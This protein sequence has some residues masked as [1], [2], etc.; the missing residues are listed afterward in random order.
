M[1]TKSPTSE[2]GIGF[3][4]RRWIH[5]R[6][7]ICGLWI[8]L[9]AKKVR[10]WFALQPIP[11]KLCMTRFCIRNIEWGVVVCRVD[12]KLNGFNN[13]IMA[14]KQIHIRSADRNKELRV[15]QQIF[16]WDCKKVESRFCGSGCDPSRVITI[17]LKISIRLVTVLQT[18]VRVRST[19]EE[20]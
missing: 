10:N 20:L 15:G 8:R 14:R 17:N 16:P 3:S 1:Q 18:D 11:R 19:F 9:D 2:G 5:K 12:K 7:S 13:E 4:S 6:N